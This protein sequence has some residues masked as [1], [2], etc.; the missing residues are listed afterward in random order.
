MAMIEIGTSGW[1][2]PHWVGRFYP[3]DLPAREQLSYYAQH[4]STVEINRS[5]YRLPTYEQFRA[6]AEQTSDHPNFRFAVKAS[7]YITHLKKL[8]NV[9]EGVQRLVSS[10]QGLGTQLGPFLYQLPPHWRANPERLKQFIKLL[11]SNYQAAFEFRD[12]TWFQGETLQTLSRILNDAGCVLAVGIGGSQ[13]T[14][15]DI[16]GTGPFRYYR[17]HHGA[18]G[19]GFSDE[20]LILWA[21]RIVGDVAEGRNV[22]V[23]FNNDPEA[24]AIR[25]ALRLR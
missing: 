6:W 3:S 7:R 16:S 14:S 13:P 2:Y 11:P 9:E 25:D 5:F 17:F 12:P 21:K 22:Y 24:Y 1:V 20:E 18:H 8:H 10:A 23:Y 4:F 15:T 19:V